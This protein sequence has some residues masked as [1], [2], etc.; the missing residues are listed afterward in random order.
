MPTHDAPDHPLA[1]ALRRAF[2]SG[3]EAGDVDLVSFRDG[4]FAFEVQA[5]EWTLR[6]EGWPVTSGFI[7]LDEEPPTS[8]ERQAALDA[9]LDNQY[10]ANL[11]RADELLDGALVAA[12][13]DSGDELSVLLARL[14]AERAEDLLEADLE[15]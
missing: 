1:A 6:L 11:R 9:A 4:G 12:L 7:A 15:T 3:L 14:L 5:D 13:E 8:T 2:A 10:L